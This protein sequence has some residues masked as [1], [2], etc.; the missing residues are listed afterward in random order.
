MPNRRRK[1]HVP[2]ASNTEHHN[3]DH[4]SNQ[5]H[6]ISFSV[7]RISTRITDVVHILIGIATPLYKPRSWGQTSAVA[8]ESLK[9]STKT[10]LV[11]SNLGSRMDT[12]VC[13][14]LSVLV[15]TCICVVSILIFIFNKLKSTCV[16]PYTHTFLQ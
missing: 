10:L 11:Q 3:Q 6:R 16:S 4:N 8:S 2:L 15:D 14:T 13:K 7:I 12:I 1:T 5:N 9:F